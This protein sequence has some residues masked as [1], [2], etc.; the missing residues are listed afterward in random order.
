[1]IHLAATRAGF[2][3]LNGAGMHLSPYMLLS[4]AAN[5]SGRMISDDGENWEWALPNPNAP[6]AIRATSTT[7]DGKETISEITFY[8]IENDQD[9]LIG[10]MT[11]NTP[12]VVDVEPPAAPGE[13][14]KTEL[15][16]PFRM[17]VKEQALDVSG[18]RGEDHFDLSDPTWSLH[19]TM[20]VGGKGGDDVI[21]GGLGN[22][23]LYGNTGDDVITDAHGN[24]ILHGGWGNDHISVTNPS[25]QS[26]LYGGRGEDIL[27]SGSGDDILRGGG[28]DDTL[29]AGSGNDKLY[30]GSGDDHLIAGVG[31]DRLKGG[32]GHDTFEINTGMSGRTV[33]R[34]FDLEDDTLLLVNFNGGLEEL[35]TEQKGNHLHLT[36][37]IG[38]FTLILRNTDAD[39][40]ADADIQIV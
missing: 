39:A 10:T 21:T 24:N 4:S 38:G 35:V 29:I 6:Y 22:D 13:T 18:S 8:R 34:D 2:H 1:M 33:I 36:D 40:F 19:D 11:L 7:I 31:D 23:R 17:A 15:A 32:K 28:G 27:S 3:L 30:G 20:V 37:T 16:L 26:K 12:L 5:A 9:V 14:W 25:G